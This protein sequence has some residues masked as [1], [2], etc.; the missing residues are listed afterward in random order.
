MA[1]NNSK[2]LLATFNKYTK[3]IQRIKAINYTASEA[4]QILLSCP[5][6]RENSFSFS[7]R[8]VKCLA[9][10]LHK[11][12]FMLVS[13]SLLWTVSIALKRENIHRDWMM[14]IRLF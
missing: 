13:F 3:Y 11:M 2:I 5:A 7:L 14:S 8:Q 12:K 1:C 9:A 10:Y 4:S 6:T